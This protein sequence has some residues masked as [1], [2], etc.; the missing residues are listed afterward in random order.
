MKFLRGLALESLFLVKSRSLQVVTLLLFLF[1]VFAFYNA[2][3]FALNFEKQIKQ[4]AFSESAAGNEGN[5]IVLD[6]GEKLR[7]AREALQGIHP[8]AGPNYALI[9]FS[10]LGPAMA[11]IV[12][13]NAVGAEFASR[14]VR[15]KAAHYGWVTSVF[16]KL[17]TIFLLGVVFAVMAAGIGLVGGKVT[18]NMI[19]ANVEMAKEVPP[20]PLRS[21]NL[22]RIMV[23]LAGFS[24]Y[25]FL[26]L[27]LTLVTRNTL[28]GAS[29]AV[30]L[31]YVEKF[32]NVW[33][34]PQAL[35]SKLLTSYFNS[36][37]GGV[38][39]IPPS[40]YKTTPFQCW[41]GMILWGAAAFFASLV[42]A[43]RQEL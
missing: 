11:A 29:A 16:A 33:W 19:L 8:V 39:F 38:V 35:Y 18:W 30:A 4:L 15:V 43:R 31:P 25:A 24:F 3:S 34:L 5:K 17:I 2:Y 6:K 28:A 42:W 20:P 32:L 14:T 23:A 40:P 21:S 7:L 27:F 41:A 9:L 26:S 22:M 13:A 37:E 1:F 36:F 12:G 10:V